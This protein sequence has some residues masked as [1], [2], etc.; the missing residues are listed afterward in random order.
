MRTRLKGKKKKEFTDHHL[1]HQSC[2]KFE[3]YPSLP[4]RLQCHSAAAMMEFGSCED[5]PAL[6]VLLPALLSY[7]SHNPPGIAEKIG[8]TRSRMK[9]QMQMQSKQVP[10]SQRV[11]SV[12]MRKETA[13]TPA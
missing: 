4:E 7:C 6:S 5:Q 12:V 8:G 2:E 3:I 11:S 9:M 13:Y 1:H 10:E